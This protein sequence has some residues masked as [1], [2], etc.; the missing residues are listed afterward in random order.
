[1][2]TDPARKT[3]VALYL[4]VSSDDQRERQTIKTQE[5]VLRHWAER[6]EERIEVVGWFKDDG[7]SGMKSHAV[8]DDSKKLLALAIQGLIDQVVI[9]RLDRLGR[10][11]RDLLDV[12]D[13]LEKHGVTIFAVLENVEDPFEY[14]L[15]AVLA[16]DERRRFLKRSKEGMERAAREGRYLGGI[17]PLGYMVEGK[18]PQAFLV[19]STVLLWESWTEADLVRQMYQWIGVEGW[20]C[21]RV[22]DHLNALGVPTVYTK[23]ERLLKD[24]HGRRVK[25]T[26]NLW[27]PSRIR[28]LIVNTMYKGLYQYG[29][30][31]KYEREIIPALVPALVSEALWDATQAQLAE[32]RL[33][34]KH[35]TRVN[36]LKSLVR[37]STCGLSFVAA[38][39]NRDVYWYKCGGQHRHRGKLQQR[40]P[41]RS[42]RADWLEPIVREDVRRWLTSPGDDLLAELQA[43][44]AEVP[45]EAASDAERT[46]VE[47]ALVSLP[48]RRERLIEMRMR[49]L[50]TIDEFE[51]KL[52]ELSREEEQL[53]RRLTNLLPSEDETAEPVDEDLLVELRRHVEVRELDDE[54]WRELIAILVKRIDAVTEPLPNGKKKLTLTIQYR[55]PNGVPHDHTGTDSSP[56]GA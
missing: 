45:G 5:D 37:C 50:V 32:N 30:R 28:N 10:T 27:R 20:S 39:A 53:R 18:K 21:V 54:T 3:R 34:T 19:P 49:D 44:R 1:M 33:I 31:T 43:E 16:A 42:F 26:E 56:R 7:I 12:R 25:R 47:H 6:E 15:R 48:S 14:E 51:Q 52:A 4:R 17:V 55:F 22:A 9:T 38:R 2:M 23:D 29:R 8:R 24:A 13:A 35:G 41:S 11:T 40:C 36:L 46:I